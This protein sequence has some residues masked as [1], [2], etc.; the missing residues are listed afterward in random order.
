MHASV[1]RRDFADV[2]CSLAIFNWSVALLIAA[3]E[4][5]PHHLNILIDKINSHTLDILHYLFKK[6]KRIIIVL[7]CCK[8][9]AC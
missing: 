2:K 6:E 7:D 9:T 8:V 4:L 5:K 1:Y 3:L